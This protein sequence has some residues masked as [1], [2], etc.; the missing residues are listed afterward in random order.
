MEVRLGA[1]VMGPDGNLGKV[2]GMIVNKRMDGVEDL[3]IHHGGLTSH[4]EHV[5]PLSYVLGIHDEGIQINLN[6]TAFEDLEMFSEEGYRARPMHY[7]APPEARDRYAVPGEFEADVM[8]SQGQAGF[9]HEKPGGYPGGEQIVSEDQQL[10]VIRLGM[11]VLDV[12]GEKIGE[13]GEF[14]VRADDG[15]PV[16]MAVREGLIF[17]HSRELPITWLKQLAGDGVVL[18]VGRQE[19]ERD[20]RAA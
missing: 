3:I 4:H 6:E 12:T 15:M 9:E 14:E 8:V 18:N 7:S 5:L 11:D 20:E 16:R 10:P 1:D 17:K 2:E 13:L 19:L